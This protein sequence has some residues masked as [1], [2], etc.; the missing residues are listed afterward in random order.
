V[1]KPTIGPTRREQVLASGITIR[2][3]FRD[4][5]RFVFFETGIE[6]HA[7]ATHGGSAFIVNYRGRCYGLTAGHVR[8][9]FEW[10]Q[11]VLTDTKFGKHKTPIRTIFH[12]SSPR[13]EAIGSDLPDVVV[14]EFVQAITPDF[15]QDATYVLDHNTIR[16]SRAGHSL[17][18]N[19]ALKEKSSIGDDIAPTFALLQ[20]T[21]AGLAGSDPAVRLA[22]AQFADRQFETLLGL[23]GA[24]VYNETANALCGMVIRGG[25]VGDQWHV[26][27]VDIFDIMQLLEAVHEGKTETNYRKVLTRVTRTP[28]KDLPIIKPAGQGTRLPM[29][30]AL[31]LV[32]RT[33]GVA[34]GLCCPRTGITRL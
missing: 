19:G 28:I 11:L 13:E 26:R 32:C 33:L 31:L 7:Y 25:P 1:N 14:I 24:P 21:D 29:R 18:V 27:Y 3:D 34:G 6:D 23:S 5:V 8:Q 17:L 15:F 10:R 9:D 2:Q 20:F 30:R 16:S 12:P 22:I 4:A